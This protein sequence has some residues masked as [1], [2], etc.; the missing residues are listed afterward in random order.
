M[1]NPKRIRKYFFI[2]LLTLITVLV[3]ILTGYTFWNTAD[4][5]KTC[6]S[7]HEIREAYE[8]WTVSAHRGF[9]CKSCHGTALSTGLNSLREAAGR[10]KMH[11]REDSIGDVHISEKHAGRVMNRCRTCH[12]DE[13][14]RWLSGG[15]SM[16]FSDVFLNEEMNRRDLVSEKCLK[17]HGMY[18]QDSFDMLM[19]PLDTIGPWKIISPNHPARYAIP[20]LACHSMHTPGQP[21]VPPDYAHPREKSYALPEPYPRAGFYNRTDKIHYRADQLPKLFFYTEDNQDTK[22]SDEP[23][24]R[25]CQ[26]C[27]T[28]DASHRAGTGNDHTPLGVH[29]GLSCMAC[30]QPHTNDARSSCKNCHPALSN[31]GLDV[32]KMNTSMADQHS[33]NDIHFV[34]CADCHQG[35]DGGKS[36]KLTY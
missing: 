6:A 9:D 30:H 18:Y 16:K 32:E 2:T 36:K 23:L 8:Q 22:V 20:C 12:Q 26:Q 28:P 27:H 19:A 13:Y 7:C 33:P 31:C 11:I 35:M 5:S 15:H 4:P 3:I 10:L 1:T 25:V 34:K 24:M 17:C 21:A 14:T 29:E